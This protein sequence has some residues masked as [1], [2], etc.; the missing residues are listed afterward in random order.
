MSNKLKETDIENLAYYFF[1]VMI[2][3]KNLDRKKILMKTCK[4]SYKN[5]LTYYIGYVT[6]KRC[7]ITINSVISSY[8]IIN[9]INEYI[10]KI[11]G[12]E[13]LTIIPA[14]ES[15]SR[16]FGTGKVNALF[17]LINKRYETDK[18]SFT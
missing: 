10:E 1:N 13:Y 12:N 3:I 7:Y 15:Q 16:G 17:N 5:S 18:E 11:N 14:D 8:L 4:N 2:N 6:V 9:E